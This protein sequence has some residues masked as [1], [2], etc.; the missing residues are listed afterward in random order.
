MARCLNPVLLSVICQATVNKYN[1]QKQLCYPGVVVRPT[2]MSVIIC[3]VN[4]VKASIDVKPSLTKL[5]TTSSK[6]LLFFS[7]LYHALALFLLHCWTLKFTISETHTSAAHNDHCY[8]QLLATYVFPCRR[9]K[10]VQYR[11]AKC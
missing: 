7:Q 6:I 9:E 4:M 8:S 10:F 5:F 1:L 3:H 11:I 2:F